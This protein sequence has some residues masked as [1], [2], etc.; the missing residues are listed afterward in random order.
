MSRYCQAILPVVAIIGPL[1]PFDL[2]IV[3]AQYVGRSFLVLK[4]RFRDPHRRPSVFLPSLP[5]HFEGH[6]VIDQS[7]SQTSALPGHRW[8]RQDAAPKSLPREAV[9]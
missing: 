7:E 9:R 3:R 8:W 6:W 5:R 1:D 2:D 4:I